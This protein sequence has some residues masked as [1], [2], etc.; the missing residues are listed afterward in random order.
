MERLTFV[1]GVKGGGGGRG[2]NEQWCLDVQTHDPISSHDKEAPHPKQAWS[3]ATGVE[4]AASNKQPRCTEYTGGRGRTSTNK[5]G[6]MFHFLRNAVHVI[7]D[8]K[9]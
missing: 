8:Q 7:M 9:I 6:W 4:R 2:G 3:L 1:E 5:I